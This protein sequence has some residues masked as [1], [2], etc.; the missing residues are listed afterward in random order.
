[1]LVT[2]AAPESVARALHDNSTRS[3][4]SYVAV[5][6]AA[7]P[8]QLLEAELFGHA[9]GAF[10]G[11][12][13]ARAGRFEAAQGGTLLLDEIGEMPLAVQV[14]LL[15][16]L[17]E[18]EVVRLGENHVR[19]VDVRVVAATHR[20]L[21]EMVQHGE[22]REDLYYRLLAAACPHHCASTRDIRYGRDAV[23]RHC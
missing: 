22:F 9:R 1:V 8:A 19:R 13:S 15:R 7:L 5:H 20:D 4:G 2:K 3:L 10:T 23:P 6:C 14:K 21:M 12:T 17:Q 11:A 18:R 16:V